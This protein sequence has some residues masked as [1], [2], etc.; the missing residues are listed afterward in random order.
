MV[1][2]LR[3]LRGHLPLP[4]PDPV[5]RS[6]DPPEPGEAFMGYPKLPGQLL[7]RVGLEALPRTDDKRCVADQLGA[8]LTALHAI[9][10]EGFDPPLAVANDRATW[11]RMYA[12]VHA[13][14]FPLMRPGARKWVSAHFEAYL[15]DPV[16]SAWTP[17]VIHGDFGPAN[18]LYDAGMR[19]VSGILDWDSSGL[20][21]PATDLAALIGDH[22]YGADFADWLAPA[23]PQL[24]AELPRARFYLGTFA[25]QEVLFGL[26]TGDTEAFEAGMADYR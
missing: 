9:P 2:L 3:A 18:I 13:G 16:S 1:A 23:Y 26:K 10:T 12:D 21:D 20:G 5:C 14:L 4:I 19:A 8:F 15:D 25:L 6:L 24:A 7:Y 11:E 22:S 17:T